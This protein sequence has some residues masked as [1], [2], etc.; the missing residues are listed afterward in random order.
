MISSTAKLLLTPLTVALITGADSAQSKRFYD[1]V[2][3]SIGTSSTYSQGMTTFYDASGKVIG[4]EST[5]GNT[6]TVYDARGRSI[7]RTTGR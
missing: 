3:R 1:L 6:T 4:R 5:T 2:G 7:G